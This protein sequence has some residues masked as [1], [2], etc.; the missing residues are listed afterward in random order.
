MFENVPCVIFVFQIWT[1]LKNIFVL[2]TI[3]VFPLDF[4]EKIIMNQSN[5]QSVMIH[6]VLDFIYITIILKSIQIKV[7]TYNKLGNNIVTI[8]F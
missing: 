7:G 2:F 4:G 5:V 3:Q 6:L 8:H 1:R